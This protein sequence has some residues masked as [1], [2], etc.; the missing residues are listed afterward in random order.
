MWFKTPPQST[1]K[2]TKLHS[3]TQ[4]NIAQ[5]P[6]LYAVKYLIKGSY[7]ANCYIYNKEGKKKKQNTGVEQP[8]SEY[9][10]HLLLPKG[11]WRKDCFAKYLSISS[12][13]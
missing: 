1:N 3:K 11:I 2:H 4:S 10:F 7:E 6:P 5:P 13:S 8:G 9:N 12:F